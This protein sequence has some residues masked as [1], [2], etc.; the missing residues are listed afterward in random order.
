MGQVYLKMVVLVM[1]LSSTLLRVMQHFNIDRVAEDSR[2]FCLQL[3]AS[4]DLLE[5]RG[6]KKNTE[7]TI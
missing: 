7:T 5:N 1:V 6:M 3:H 4:K 2:N